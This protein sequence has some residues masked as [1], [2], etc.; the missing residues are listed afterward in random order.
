[1]N[2]M[3]TK[4]GK[5]SAVQVTIA[6]IVAIHEA[7]QR[8]STCGVNHAL[9]HHLDQFCGKQTTLCDI[10]ER[11]CI[12]FAEFLKA[13][14]AMSSVKTYLQKLHAILEHAV[15][16][17]LIDC[18]PMPAVR[19][20]IPR[21]RSSQRVYLTQ[22]ELVRL[23]S[24]PC[25]HEETKRAFLFACQTGL[26]L[27][28]IETLSWNDIT[29]INGSPTIVKVQVKT[30]Q[31]VCV[32]LN[33][34]ALELIG[35][36]NGHKRVFDL[37]SRSVIAS[38]LL[39][40]AKAAGVDKHLTFHVSRHTF[41]TL[42]ISAGVDIYVVSRLCGHRSVRTTEIYAHIIDKTLQDGVAL[43]ESAMMNNSRV[44]KVRKLNIKYMVNRV[45]MV[46]ESVFFPKSQGNTK[47]RYILNANCLDTKFK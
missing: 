18:N 20:L 5:K 45:K 23:A 12:A 11:F 27:S 6:E 43:L 31:E 42:S 34:V 2:D 22:S 24:K 33:T 21:T 16:D 25:N 37:K 39:S 4:S 41:A 44:D 7:K 26:R 28:D 1:M 47:Q 38:D 32:P 13:K 30:C 29:E 17:H 3:N 36:R 14:V 10:S 8:H 46:I 9:M 40:W 35:E 19:F 15:F